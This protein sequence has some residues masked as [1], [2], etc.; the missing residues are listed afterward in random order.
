MPLGVT[1]GW[2]LSHLRLG[3]LGILSYS[4]IPQS[5]PFSTLLFLL[6]PQKCLLLLSCSFSW[7]LMFNIFKNRDIRCY[8]C[9]VSKW[10]LHPGAFHR[11][12]QEICMHAHEYI[13]AFC[14][15]PL[16]LYSTNANQPYIFQ[17]NLSFSH[18]KESQH[19][20]V[21]GFIWVHREKNPEWPNPYPLK[22]KFPNE[23]MI[24]F[25]S[26]SFLQ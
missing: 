10:S 24:M 2:P 17:C 20:L 21:L 18:W 26:S 25:E 16:V 12:A 15:I 5:M 8:I 9:F 6:Q 1:L 3:T 19:T 22:I 7:R 14:M 11:Q 13:S 23:M 4:L